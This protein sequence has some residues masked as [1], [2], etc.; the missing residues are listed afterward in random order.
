MLSQP[1]LGRFRET[2]SQGAGV[3]R[4]PC[5]VHTGT[6][7]GRWLAELTRIIEAGPSR[8]LVPVEFSQHDPCQLVET[9]LDELIWTEEEWSQ[10]HRQT[11]A[12]HEASPTAYTERVK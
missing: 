1:S 7:R 9:V 8:R 11:S 5:F 3:T 2:Y 6:A 12:E 4:K 10:F